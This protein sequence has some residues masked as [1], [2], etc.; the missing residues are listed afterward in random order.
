METSYSFLRLINLEGSLK[1]LFLS[2]HTST[3]SDELRE[4]F[5]EFTGIVISS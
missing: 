3:S 4:F 2:K 1:T 5:V